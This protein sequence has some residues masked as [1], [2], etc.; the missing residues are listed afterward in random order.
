MCTHHGH[1]KQLALGY[2]IQRDN[3]VTMYCLSTKRVK[4]A[5]FMGPTVTILIEQFF[6]DTT[7]VQ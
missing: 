7:A 1:L 5:L 6:N 2:F 4:G 3:I